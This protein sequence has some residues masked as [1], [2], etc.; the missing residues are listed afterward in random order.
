MQELWNPIQ[1]VRGKEL[2]FSTL[3]GWMNGAHFEEVAVQKSG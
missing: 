3:A 1:L 2:I